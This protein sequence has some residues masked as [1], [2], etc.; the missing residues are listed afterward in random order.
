MSLNPESANTQRLRDTAFPDTHFQNWE[1][2]FQIITKEDDH[3][4]AILFLRGFTG[5][6]ELRSFR[7]DKY[8]LMRLDYRW[9][10]LFKN[11]TLRNSPMLRRVD[12]SNERLRVAAIFIR[13]IFDF[14]LIEL[15]KENYLLMRI[16]NKVLCRHQYNFFLLNVRL[17]CLNNSL[18]FKLII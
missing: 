18:Q 17:K 1:L 16:K 10:R 3:K 2:P 12:S 11:C 15:R 5:S 4:I 9:M 13:K 8:S 6:S 7:H 14:G